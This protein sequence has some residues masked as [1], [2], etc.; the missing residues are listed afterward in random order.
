MSQI[1]NFSAGPAMLPVDVLQQAQQELCNWNS[2]GI[3]VME[4]S[5]RSDA[6]MEIVKQ[7]EQNLRELLKIPDNY[8][9]LFCHGGARG[10][11]AALPLNLFQADE[12]VDYIVGGYW[13]K[14]AA[15]EAAKY[16]TVNEIDI[17]LE[18][19]AYLSMLPME[20]WPLTTQAKYL[21]YCPN[22]TIDGIAIH[23]L[24]DF[25]ADKIVIADY[26]SAILSQPLDV[27]R[28]G[29][30][31]AGAQKNIGP[32][33]ITLVII[34]EDLLGQARKTTP[35]ILDYTILAKN[36]SMYNTPPT[37]AW[38]LSGMVFKWLKQQGGLQE[39]ARRNQEKARLVYD[40]IDNSQFYINRVDSINRSLMNVP[41]QMEKPH[42]DSEFIQAAE[43]QGLLF[44]K[45]HKAAGGMR[46]S[47]YNAMP[48]AGVQ[49]LV[50]FMIDFEQR[51]K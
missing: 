3:S 30:I 2:L 28:F 41:F 9:I 27:S 22:E 44:L 33:G 25:A 36:D 45:G 4:I 49:K 40:V 46:A 37:F 34:R 17:R 39:I 11:F 1:Y 6:F 24:P 48:L 47:I 38:Y 32:A 29:V 42:L 21:H 35:S 12:T 10:Q 50:D 20:E 7:A 13:A 8:K 18:K 5:H 51:N 26:S 23:T 16:C 14:S 31:Y 15:Q 43:Q 19:S